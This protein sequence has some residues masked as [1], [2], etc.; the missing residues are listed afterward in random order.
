MLKMSC[1]LTSSASN[2]HYRLKWKRK[3][4]YQYGNTKHKFD[5]R[6]NEI[7]CNTTRKN[8][9]A[10]ALNTLKSSASKSSLYGTDFREKEYQTFNLKFFQF[11]IQNKERE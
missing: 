7:F 3:F 2:R 11:L 8:M 5:T 6:D 10:R 9:I 4:Q 1:L